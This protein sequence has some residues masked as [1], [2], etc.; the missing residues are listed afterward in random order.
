MKKILAIA[1][2]IVVSVFGIQYAA[3]ADI[4]TGNAINI[5][6]ESI[7]ENF[8]VAGGSVNLNTTFEKD[9]FVA[10]GKIMIGGNIAGDLFVMGGEIDITGVVTGDVR[11]IGGQ[12][13]VLGEVAGDLVIVGGITTLAPESKVLGQS[14]FIGGEL[15]Q[16]SALTQ[17]TKMLVAN[18][19]L[20]DV[21]SGEAGVTTQKITFGSGANISGN[22]RYYSPDKAEI[23]NGAIVAGGVVFN[24]IKS[25]QEIGIVK[26]TILNLIS[27]WIILKFV[28]TLIIAFV[29]VFVF[30][31]FT[32]GVND[33]ALEAF[34]KNALVGAL[35]LLAVPIIIAV[36]F[37]TLIAMPIG[38]LILLVYIFTLIIAPSIAGIII[39]SL[40]HR[41]VVS[42]GETEHYVSFRNTVVGVVLFTV[43]QFVPYVG[44]VTRIVCLLVALGAVYR[45]VHNSIIK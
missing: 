24:E 29:F 41:L 30:K 39:G 45:Y 34:T 40:I 20:D 8:Y 21:V 13:R 5:V 37:V 7:S 6:N 1:V 32:Q 2:C 28:T 15:W 19:F 10:G 31:V 14:I 36:L 3:S 26:S 18:V 25:I 16:E 42:E 11:I 35:V 44:A 22:F 23:I 27:V 33:T 12:V 38:F 4:Q 43:L 17:Q 9:V